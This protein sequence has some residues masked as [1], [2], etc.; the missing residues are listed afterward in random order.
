MRKYMGLGVPED[1]P[2]LPTMWAKVFPFVRLVVLLR[3]H[4]CWNTM[5]KPLKFRDVRLPQDERTFPVMAMIV[6]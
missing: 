6:Q 1:Y 4:G 5:C 3:A 2:S